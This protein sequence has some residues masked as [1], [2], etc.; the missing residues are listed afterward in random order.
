MSKQKRIGIFALGAIFSL[1]VAAPSFAVTVN[2]GD[3]VT[4]DWGPAPNNQF[5]TNPTGAFRATIGGSS[6]T[7]FCL[8]LNENFTP[9][10][11]YRVA[12]TGLDAIGG[13][14]GNGDPGT[15]PRSNDT[16]IDTISPQT[17]FLYDKFLKG[18]IPGY[19]G[20]APAQASLQL[21]F[22]FL[23]NEVL[24]KKPSGRE[25]D[26]LYFDDALANGG[27]GLAHS[28]V[29]IALDYK[30]DEYFGVKVFNPVTNDLDQNKI[31]SMLYQEGDPNQPVPEPG[32]MVLLGSGL[33]GLA[34]WGRK[35]FRR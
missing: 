33:A 8:E 20:S 29:A 24:E 34:V 26:Q 6:W 16:G 13:G 14:W 27:N 28:F 5:A 35:K 17:A 7:T 4:L 3:I 12:S 22:Y 9:G 25:F 31:Q 10:A 18:T 32:T 2:V 19:D 23:E 1:L 30:G 15:D 11:S 21:S